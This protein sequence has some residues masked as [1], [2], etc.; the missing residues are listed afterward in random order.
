M[1]IRRSISWRQSE[2]WRM[3]VTTAFIVLAF[4]VTIPCGAEAVDVEDDGPTDAALRVQSDTL[5]ANVLASVADKRA[6]I[7]VGKA[8]ATAGHKES[9]HKSNTQAASTARKQNAAHSGYQHLLCPRTGPKGSED[10]TRG[11]SGQGA[12]RQKR[13]GGEA[14]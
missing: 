13:E 5:A 8:I 14:C 7:D 11:T 6:G 2:Q 3:Q 9:V 1:G 10:P 12:E 4:L